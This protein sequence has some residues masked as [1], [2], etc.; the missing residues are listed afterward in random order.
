VRYSLPPAPNKEADMREKKFTALYGA[1]ASVELD[2]LHWNVLKDRIVTEIGQRMDL[3]ALA[4]TKREEA[5]DNARL[6][7]LIDEMD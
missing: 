2:A 5:E 6:A 1:E 3:D 4:E 7:R